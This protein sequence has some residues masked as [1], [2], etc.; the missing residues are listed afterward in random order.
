MTNKQLGRIGLSM[1]INYFTIAG[2]TVSLPINDTQWYDLII[3]KDGIIE[4]VQC[5]CTDTDEGSI[6][7]RSKGGT[8]GGVY[9]NVIEHEQLNWLFCVD[10][11]RKCFLI[12]VK[13]LIGNN[14][15]HS[16]RL[17]YEK[18]VNGQ[19]FQ[20]FPYLLNI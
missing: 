6:D 2:Y 13:D 10:K 19:G 9:D 8:D 15:H 16:I 5:K 11:N 4:T 12:P 14:V 3:E 18:T 20:T 1:A 17:R 7:L